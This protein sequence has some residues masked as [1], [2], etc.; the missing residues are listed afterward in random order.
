[1]TFPEHKDCACA[2]FLCNSAGWEMVFLSHET[3]E[4]LKNVPVPH[5][6]EPETF[7]FSQEGGRPPHT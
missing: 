6:D 4:Q 7:K 2:L 3:L 5:W 1:M